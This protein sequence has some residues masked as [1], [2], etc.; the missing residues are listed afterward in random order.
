FYAIVAALTL[1]FPLGAMMLGIAIRIEAEN[2]LRSVT[3]DIQRHVRRALH[4][5]WPLSGSSDECSPL[6]FKVKDEEGLRATMEDARVVHS[7]AQ[8]L[9][10][11]VRYFHQLFPVARLLLGAGMLCAV[12]LCSTI[13][14]VILVHHFP[15][16]PYLW[17]TYCGTVFVGTL[18]C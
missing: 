10:K 11:K 12:L 13:L 17:Q 15:S 7:L 3:D 2:A 4:Q 14:G 6:S 1:V 8:G 18:S 16:M 5:Q 9:L